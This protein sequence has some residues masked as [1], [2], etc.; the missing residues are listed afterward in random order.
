M[1]ALILPQTGPRDLTPIHIC[2]V[3]ECPLKMRFMNSLGGPTD[4]ISIEHLVS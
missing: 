2:Q 4:D 3:S 1:V